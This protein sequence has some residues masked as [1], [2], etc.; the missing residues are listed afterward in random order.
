MYNEKD[1]K[2]AVDGEKESAA[3]KAIK[4]KLASCD[5]SGWLEVHEFAD[6]GRLAYPLAK[7]RV[8][9]TEEETIYA[10]HTDVRREY[11]K[12]RRQKDPEWDDLRAEIA[13][14]YRNSIPE[15]HES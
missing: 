5:T 12:L 3:M 13:L 11:S 2:L 9:N 6:R 10:W 14:K 8:R 7:T 1:T 15:K 4:A